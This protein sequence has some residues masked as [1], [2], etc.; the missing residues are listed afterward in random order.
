MQK[1]KSI[2]MKTTITLL[3]IGLTAFLSGCGEDTE[4]TASVQVPILLKNV[5]VAGP[6]TVKVTLTGAGTEPTQT[7][8][9]LIVQSGKDKVYVTVDEVPRGEDWLIDIDMRRVLNDRIV[10]YQGHGQLLFSGRDVTNISPYH[11][12]GYR[13]SICCKRLN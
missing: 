9:D 2:M 8:Q 10:V 11:G 1:L 7:E 6:Y 5:T 4:E 13:P 12:G 3:V